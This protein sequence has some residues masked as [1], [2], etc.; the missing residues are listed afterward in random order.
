MKALLDRGLVRILGKKD[1]PGRPL[2]YRTAKRFLEVFGLGSLADLP[3]L[4]QVEELQ[5]AEET[6]GTA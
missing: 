3:T 6:D 1:V 4:R 5:M 2:L